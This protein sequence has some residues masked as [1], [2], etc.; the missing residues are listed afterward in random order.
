MGRRGR[1]AGE[2]VVER[3]RWQR[4][5][6]L[7]T[8]LQACIGRLSSEDRLALRTASFFRQK[9]ERK[10]I[11][12]VRAAAQRVKTTEVVLHRKKGHHSTVIDVGAGARWACNCAAVCKSASVHSPLAQLDS[13]PG[14]ARE[15]VAGPAA[16]SNDAASLSCPSHRWLVPGPLPRICASICAPV[17]L[18]PGA[19]SGEPWRLAHGDS[20]HSRHSHP[21]H[22]AALWPTPGQTV[23][24]SAMELPAAL[25]LDIA[26]ARPLVPGYPSPSR[27]CAMRGFCHA[28][29]QSTTEVYARP[30]R[31]DKSALMFPRSHPAAAATQSP[32]IL[33]STCNLPSHPHLCATV[34][35]AAP[36]RSAVPPAATQSTPIRTRSCT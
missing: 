28:Q 25:Q 6:G 8:D 16:A 30:H 2:A 33:P 18:S 10:R 22:S 14:L 27:L 17:Q 13:V 36:A 5:P 3:R 29:Q 7:P 9:A 20:R 19:R 1:G 26:A 35:K 15:Y 31:P 32:A 23:L 21:S 11:G 34:G 12:R 4:V 24:G